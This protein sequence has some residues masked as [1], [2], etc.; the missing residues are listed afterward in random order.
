[1]KAVPLIVALAC[2]AFATLTGCSDGV[3]PPSP[4]FRSGFERGFDGFNLAGVGEVDPKV[5]EVPRGTHQHAAKFELRGHQGRSELIVGG[6]GGEDNGATIEFGEGDERWLGFSFDVLRMDWGPPRFFNLIMQFK[7]E[8]EGSP[9][10]AIQLARRGGDRGIWTSGNA[11]GHSRFLAPVSAR[12][13]HRVELNFRASD[14]GAGFYRL[15]LDGRLIDRR[16][17]VS[18]IPPGRQRA[19]IKLGLYRDGL[20]LD[21]PSATLVDSVRIGH[22]RTDVLDSGR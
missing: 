14:H 7:G 9:N 2:G 20:D 18:M 11:M 13:W 5:V 10:F 17:G 19:Y 22:L 15:F 12:R 6:D 3:V 8:G 21:R 4:S 1:V 16:H